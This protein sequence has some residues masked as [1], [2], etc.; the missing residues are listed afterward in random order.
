MEREIDNHKKKDLGNV[1]CDNTTCM[2][3]GD[4]PKCY[5]SRY[6]DCLQY[7]AKKMFDETRKAQGKNGERQM[8]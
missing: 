8:D 1:I 5:L 7:K 3:R 6:A 2:E 4:F